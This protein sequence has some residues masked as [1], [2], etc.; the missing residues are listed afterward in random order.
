M[1]LSEV[2]SESYLWALGSTMMFKL[3]LCG[4]QIMLSLNDYYFAGKQVVSHKYVAMIPLFT[5]KLF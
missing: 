5:E 2:T 4:F 3:F 1:K